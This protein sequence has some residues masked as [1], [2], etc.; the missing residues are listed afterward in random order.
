[1]TGGEQQQRRDMN[2][3]DATADKVAPCFGNR[4]LLEL[5]QTGLHRNGCD[6]LGQAIAELE[7]L[8][9]SLRVTRAMTDQHDAGRVIAVEVTGP[10][11][12]R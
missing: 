10:F 9:R 4:R 7:E 12:N 2:V 6:K 3:C 5:Q 1:M 8:R 11:R